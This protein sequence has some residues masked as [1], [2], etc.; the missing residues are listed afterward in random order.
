MVNNEIK[1]FV[2]YSW[3]TKKHR[4]TVSNFVNQLRA[5]G[6]TVI[7]DGDIEL[8]DRLPQFMED[9]V[10]ESDFVILI[11]TPYYK[12]KADA[13]KAGVG[14][15]NTILTG[16]LYYKNNERKFIPILFSA[17]W[18]ESMPYWALGKLGVE[19]KGNKYDCEAY[20]TLI[21]TL[22]KSKTKK[23]ESIELQVTTEDTKKNKSPNDTDK[24][25]SSID[26]ENV[27]IR[28]MLFQTFEVNDQKKSHDG[29]L[30]LI[31][32]L[33]AILLFGIGFWFQPDLLLQRWFISINSILLIFLFVRNVLVA[34]KGEYVTNTDRH[35]TL[36][37][38][39]IDV[40]NAKNLGIS[41]SRAILGSLYLPVICFACWQIYSFPD[42]TL[43]KIAYGATLFAFLPTIIT[44]GYGFVEKECIGEYGVVALSGFLPFIQ[45]LAF[46]VVFILNCI[47]SGV[48]GD[49]PIGSKDIIAGTFVSVSNFILVLPERYGKIKKRKQLLGSILMFYIILSWLLYVFSQ[50]L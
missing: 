5:D 46:I 40:E 16:E 4:K 22:K 28:D 1:V 43:L 2:S 12:V 45:A 30:I 31:A 9:S 7:Y 26:Y 38:A 27:S 29:I 39:I 50:S 15:E 37:D 14:Y 35:E 19:L 48:I 41:I 24:E 17:S 11:C 44:F 33:V 42:E 3:D 25:V 23:K 21:A 18:E 13:R 6:L 20:S 47:S 49:L 8:G 36:K 10:R 34:M 32:F